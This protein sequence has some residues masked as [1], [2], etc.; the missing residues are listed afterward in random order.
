MAQKRM[1]SKKITQTDLF[2]DMP[3]SAQAF[4]FHLNLE[5][6][7]DGFVSNVK[8]LRRITNASEDDLRLLIAKQFLIAFENGV[9][10][11]KD[12]RIHNYIKKDRYSETIYTNEKDQLVLNEQNQYEFCMQN[13]AIMEPTCNHSIDKI[14]LDK[15][16]IDKISKSEES[17]VIPYAEIISYLNEKANTNYRTGA[18][19]TKDL[20]KARWNEGFRL[21][22]FKKVIDNKSD[23]WM[24]TEWEKYLRPKT[25]FKTNFESYLNQKEKSKFQKRKE[26]GDVISEE[27]GF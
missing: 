4:Y 21:E 6:D 1:F 20:I 18:Q 5:A 25:L 9:V 23:E 11:V 8:T 3:L 15:I 13:G 16:S 17:D 7:D 27:Y 2:L 22:D 10:V 24:G 19:T 12:W 14:S 26:L